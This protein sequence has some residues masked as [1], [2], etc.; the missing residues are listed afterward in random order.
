M[1]R[2]GANKFYSSE[3]ALSESLLPWC[4]DNDFF[5]LSTKVFKSVSRKHSTNVCHVTGSLPFPF[6]HCLRISTVMSTG[7]PRLDTSIFLTLFPFSSFRSKVPNLLYSAPISAAMSICPFAT[8]KC[9]RVPRV[10]GP[11]VNLQEYIQQWLNGD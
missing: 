5:M 10:G 7:S 9:R 11:S 1:V 8:G 6:S 3:G 4:S 2:N